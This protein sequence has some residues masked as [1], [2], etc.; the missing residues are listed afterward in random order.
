MSKILLIGEP[1]ALL[2]AQE[3]G[4]LAL[5][6]HFERRLA[7]A[8][9]NVS[10]GLTRLGHE[11]VYFTRIGRDPFGEY[12]V[13]MLEKERIATD[14]IMYDDVY[15]TGIQLKNKV[16]EGDPTTA[17][18]RKGSAFSHLTPDDIEKIDLSTIDYIHVTGIPPALSTGCEEATYRLVERAKAN[19]I[20][21]S[22]DPNLRPALWQ[23]QDHMKQ[24]INRLA[25]KADL[26]LPGQEEG[27][28]LCGTDDPEKIAD[29]Y[30][31]LGI[32]KIVVKTGSAGA[33]VREGGDSYTV[34]GFK[35]DQVV[36]TV[37]A[38][39]GFAAGVISG[40]AE[41]IPLRDAVLRGNA[42]GAIQVTHISDNEGLP[43]VDQLKSFMKGHA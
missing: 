30:Q 10:I 36:D 16:T 38:G 42:I 29:F 15:K 17:Y 6:D 33:Y 24:V 27:L 41:G 37:G 35:V 4:S 1:M 7:G 26:I 13:N 34:P 21:L 3:P 2:I 5:A 25:S 20:F 43:T 18:Y 40:I 32:D 14:Y 23:D 31:G 11:A 19:D 28:L 12:V 22:F 8:E 9:I 39:D